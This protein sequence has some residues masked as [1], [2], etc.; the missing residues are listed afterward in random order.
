MVGTGT[1][2]GEAHLRS[3]HTGAAHSLTDRGHLSGTFL[4]L[5]VSFATV[6][7]NAKDVN[8]VSSFKPVCYNNSTVII[9][10][11]NFAT[12]WKCGLN[13]ANT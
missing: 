9:T 2:E 8:R 5:L 3:L 11:L 12:R 4:F 6:I 7:Q 1:P 10:T 13:S